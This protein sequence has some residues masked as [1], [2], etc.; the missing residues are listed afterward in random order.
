MILSR[1]NELQASSVAI[2]PSS[3]LYPD[4]EKW[5]N[6]LVTFSFTSSPSLLSLLEIGIAGAHQLENASLAVQLC[7]QWLKSMS[8]W[9]EGEESVS[10]HGNY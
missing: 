2:A 10:R 7:R 9:N 4:R 3:S 6:I 8:M 1:G 5:S